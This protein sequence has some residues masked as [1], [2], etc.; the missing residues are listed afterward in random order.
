MKNAVNIEL[1]A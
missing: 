1:T